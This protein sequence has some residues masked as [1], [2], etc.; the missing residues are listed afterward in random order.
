MPHR[1]PSSLLPFPSSPTPPNHMDQMQDMEDSFILAADTFLLERWQEDSLLSP[2]AQREQIFT[3]FVASA[4]TERGLLDRVR[5]PAAERFAKGSRNEDQFSG[6]VVSLID[7]TLHDFGADW[8][9][10]FLGIPQLLEFGGSANGYN[11]RL[12]K[13]LQEVLRRRRGGRQ[14]G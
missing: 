7:P 9:K 6:E 11:K 14:G 4:S 13:A 3:E 1:Q 2:E 5:R 10:D 12:Q 8:H